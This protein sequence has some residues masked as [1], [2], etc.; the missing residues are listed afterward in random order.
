VEIAEIKWC[1]FSK[2][3]DHFSQSAE[4]IVYF[5]FFSPAQPLFIAIRKFVQTHSRDD[6][7][8]HRHSHH[9]VVVTRK[10]QQLVLKKQE[11]FGL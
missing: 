10:S 11:Y 5:R 1:N 7:C 6:G 9:K 2:G 3:P 8:F 4:N